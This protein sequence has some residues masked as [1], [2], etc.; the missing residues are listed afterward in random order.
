MRGGP[1]VLPGR[2]TVRLIVGE[3]SR[4]HTLEILPD[5]RLKL[6]D[7]QIA[8]AGAY[9]EQVYDAIDRVHTAVNTIRK[10]RA[11][12]GAT[13]KRAKEAGVAGKLKDEAK[14][15]RKE[16]KD[17]EDALIQSKSKSPQDPLNF[18]VR[19]NDKLTMLLNL[20]NRDPRPTE[21]EREVLANLE[22]RVKKQ[23]DALEAVL[24]KQI[25]AFNEAAAKAPVPA[26]VLPP[27][28]PSSDK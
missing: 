7:E 13:M 12:I 28:K 8:A 20:T 4:E 25:P 6:T 23:L 14:A 9:S 5:P 17:I 26:V 11:Q 22:E 1:R 18:P 10:V 19:L 15:L 3:E 16:L 21:S 2:Y 24:S 27:D